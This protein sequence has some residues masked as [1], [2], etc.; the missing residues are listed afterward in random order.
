MYLAT[1]DHQIGFKCKHVTDMCI[2]TVKRIINYN[3]EQNTVVYT[4][5]LNASKAFG[6]INHWTLFHKLIYCKI[7]LIIVRF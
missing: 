7:P 6:M 1:L 4:C 5:F 2:S 3:T